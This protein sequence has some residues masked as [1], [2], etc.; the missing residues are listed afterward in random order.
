MSLARFPTPWLGVLSLGAVGV[1]AAAAW[2]LV[3]S[4]ATA[5]EVTAAV[6]AGAS[7]PEVVVH[8]RVDDPTVPPL[9]IQ[10][11]TVEKPGASPFKRPVALSSERTFDLVLG[12]PVPGRYA[13][14]VHW[15]QQ[16]LWGEPQPS[17][18]IVRLTVASAAAGPQARVRAYDRRAVALYGLAIAAAGVGTAFGLLRAARRVAAGKNAPA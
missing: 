17:E 7:G 2:P 10:Q 4:W 6:V 13:I 3:A 14:T 11:V 18:L 5:A 9:G 8:G 1:L 12:P 16:P 15:H